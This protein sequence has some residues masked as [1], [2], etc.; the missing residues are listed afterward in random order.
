MYAREGA[1]SLVCGVRKSHHI[2]GGVCN[3]PRERVRSFDLLIIYNFTF[4]AHSP[5]VLTNVL[6][7]KPVP[8]KKITSSFLPAKDKNCIYLG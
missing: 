1:S 7:V 6:E 3:L 8:K 4:F 5:R 2:R